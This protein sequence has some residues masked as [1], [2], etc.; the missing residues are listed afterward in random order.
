MLNNEIIS[1]L[2]RKE[3]LDE[4]L[5]DALGD[6]NST[7]ADLLALFALVRRLKTEAEALLKTKS[8]LLTIH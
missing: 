6:P 7:A 4:A 5:E 8:A 2:E 1:V 3:E